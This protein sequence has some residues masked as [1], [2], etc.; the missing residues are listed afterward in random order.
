[1]VMHLV[2][3]CGAA[4]WVHL[5]EDAPLLCDF[6]SMLICRYLWMDTYLAFVTT[7]GCYLIPFLIP[8]RKM[9]WEP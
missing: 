8:A 2:L 9:L 4:E 6:S 1:M 7:L 5:L 3:P